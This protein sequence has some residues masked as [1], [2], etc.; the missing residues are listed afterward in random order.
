MTSRSEEELSSLIVQGWMNVWGKFS[1][2]FITSRVGLYGDAYRRGAAK[3]KTQRNQM[4]GNS[5]DKL[6]HS[7]SDAY[8]AEQVMT[9]AIL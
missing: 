7:R 1:T 5:T 9:R 3:Y 2:L 4:R 8:S 6:R